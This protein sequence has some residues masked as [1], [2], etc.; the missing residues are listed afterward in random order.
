MEQMYD[1]DKVFSRF[2][3]SSFL[4]RRFISVDEGG[5]VLQG[6]LG[7]WADRHGIAWR[8]RE[9]SARAVSGH[10]VRGLII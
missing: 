7:R 4:C 6:C 9:D 5:C 10:G 8:R 1:H 3:F 2:S